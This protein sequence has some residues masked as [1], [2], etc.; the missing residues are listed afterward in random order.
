M[1]IPELYITRGYLDH[2]LIPKVPY[3]QDDTEHN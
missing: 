2:L 1:D 3:I